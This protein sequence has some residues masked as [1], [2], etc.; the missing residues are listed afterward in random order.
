[1]SQNTIWLDGGDWDIDA[2]MSE[3]LATTGELGPPAAPLTGG[4]GALVAAFGSTSEIDLTLKGTL[5][6]RSEAPTRYFVTLQGEAIKNKLA[7]F[8]GKVVWRYVAFGN[9]FARWVPYHVKAG[10]Q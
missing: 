2:D 4:T 6:Q 10:R 3:K 5:A 1:M 8:V 9:D 7:S